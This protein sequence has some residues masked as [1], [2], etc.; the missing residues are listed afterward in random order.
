MTTLGL[1]TDP[2]HFAD[3]FADNFNTGDLYRVVAFY[4]DDAVLNLGGGNIFAGHDAIR[5]A[6]A[7]FLA[8][9][10]PISVSPRTAT[11]SRD[12]AIVTFDWVITGNDPSGA[13]VAMAGRAIDVLR[14]T[15]HGWQ[16]LLDLPFG[17]ETVPA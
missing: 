15:P 1:P 10:L 8:P 3:A 9:K 12:T 5:S 13:P 2:A 4:S 7:N 14:R 16:Q 17:A 6:L 11:V